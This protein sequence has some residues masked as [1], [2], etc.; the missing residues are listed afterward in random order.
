MARE[1]SKT[2]PAATQPRIDRISGSGQGDPYRMPGKLPDPSVCPRCGVAYHNGSWT[3]E[4]APADARATN[5][6]RA[7]GSPMTIPPES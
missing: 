7:G 6:R 3:W 2:H 4:P 1:R 5:A